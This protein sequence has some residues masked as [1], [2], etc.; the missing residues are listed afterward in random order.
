[1]TTLLLSMGDETETISSGDLTNTLAGSADGTLSLARDV[2]A[3]L[4]NAPLSAL[5]RDKLSVPFSGS[6][7]FGRDLNFG[8]GGTLKIGLSPDV[9][10]KITILRSGE[11]FR[12]SEAETD[13]DEAKSQVITVPPGKA[14]VSILLRVSLE[15]SGAG[16]F[17]HGAFGVKAN[18]DS[19]NLFRLANHCCVDA[20]QGFRD[21]IVTAF[22]R[23]VLPFQDESAAKL[24]QNDFLE[25][26]FFGKLAFGAAVTAGFG[27]VFFG[28]R[29]GGELMRS[30]NSPVGSIVARAKPSFNL[31]A[32]LGVDYQHEDAFRMNLC[33][34]LPAL[35]AD[36]DEATTQDRFEE[37]LDSIKDLV[38]KDAPNF[39][40]FFTKPMLAALFTQMS[41]TI[42]RIDGPGSERSDYRQ[43]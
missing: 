30:L 10:G 36:L 4:Q 5:S 8:G 27:G 11:V 33:E 26:E 34:D 38:K 14:Y 23:F 28:G 40:L 43:L 7:A 15:A 21:A 3:G 24:Q 39:P 25:Y 9:E 16:G 20:S 2:I 1:M 6:R 13:D 32:E 22:T 37:L 18:I 17:S 42:T 19:N 41:G 12:F 35:A 29:S 31:G